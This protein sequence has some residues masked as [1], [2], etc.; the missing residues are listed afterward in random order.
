[1]TDQV[2]RLRAALA[3][4]YAALYAYGRLGVL[5]EKEIRPVAHDAEAAHQAR[6]DVLIV[7]LDEIKAAPVDPDPAYGLPFA[8]TDRDAALRLAIQVEDRVA[9]TWRGAL[10]STSPSA[11]ATVITSPSAAASSTASGGTASTG[12]ASTGSASAGTAPGGTAN[13]APADPRRLALAGF[14]DA[15]ARATRWRKIAGVTPLTSVFPGRQG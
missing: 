15:A 9:A 5:L 3:A 7:H 11:P 6:R 4:E 2:E 13:P 1:M 8:V 14:A 10:A 12:A